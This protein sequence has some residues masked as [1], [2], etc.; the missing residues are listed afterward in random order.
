MAV[1]ARHGLAALVFLTFGIPLVFIGFQTAE[2]TGHRDIEG[3]IS[4]TLVRKH[5]GGLYK[6]RRTIS[7]IK[8]AEIVTSESDSG[9]ETKLV[10]N[11]VLVSRLGKI[12]VFLGSSNSYNNLKKRIESEVNTFIR[13]PEQIQYAAIYSMRDVFGA[14]GALL[15]FFGFFILYKWLRNAITIWQELRNASKKPTEGIQ[16]TATK[17]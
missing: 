5:L 3:E 8:W 17:M 1:V 12:P 16:D 7:Q 2:L 11:V 10:S 13:D 4:F 15:L 9:T 14:V 6:I